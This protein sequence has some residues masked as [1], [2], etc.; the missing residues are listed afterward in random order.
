MTSDSS[1]PPPTR[2]IADLLFLPE[3][4]RSLVN[5]LLRQHSATFSEVVAHLSQAPDAVQLLL[6]NLIAEGIVRSIEENDEL[7]YQ[8]RLIT[9]VGRQVP[10]KIWNALED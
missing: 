2:S 9:R 7:R 4:E 8:P 6:E 5:W 3:A 10:R 1:Q